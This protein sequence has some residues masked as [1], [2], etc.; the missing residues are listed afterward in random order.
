MENKN[1]M[2]ILKL[3]DFGYICDYTD[4]VIPYTKKFLQERFHDKFVYDGW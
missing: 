2:E 1:E 4:I 3:K